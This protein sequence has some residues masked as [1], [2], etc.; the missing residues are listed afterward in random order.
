MIESECF[1]FVIGLDVYLHI[2][3]IIKPYFDRILILNN[4]RYSNKS[5]K[6]MSD[7]TV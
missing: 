7:L 6:L 2:A 5:F 1:L 3:V 4:V